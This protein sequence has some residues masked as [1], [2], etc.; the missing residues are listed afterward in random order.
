MFISLYFILIVLILINIFVF[1]N[2]KIV[3]HKSNLLGT[4]WH[5]AVDSSAIILQ[6]PSRKLILRGGAAVKIDSKGKV[7]IIFIESFYL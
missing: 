3:F 6:S 7:L 5:N 1:S 4:V 2:A